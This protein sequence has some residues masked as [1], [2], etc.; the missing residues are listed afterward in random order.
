VDEILVDDLD[1]GNGKTTIYHIVD[2][3]N[4]PDKE[5]VPNSND[6]VFNSGDCYLIVYTY[7]SK[8]AGGRREKTIIY[9]WLV[10]HYWAQEMNT[11]VSRYF[12]TAVQFSPL[13]KDA[14]VQ[15][16]Y[17]SSLKYPQIQILA[18]KYAIVWQRKHIQM[19][20]ESRLSL[21]KCVFCQIVQQCWSN[22]KQEHYS[23]S[24]PYSTNLK[25]RK[26]PD[27]FEEG[28]KPNHYWKRGTSP[29]YRGISYREVLEKTRTFLPLFKFHY[30]FKAFVIFNTIN[31]P[32]KWFWPKW[33]RQSSTYGR[34]C[35]WYRIP[36]WSSS[37][38]DALMYS[39]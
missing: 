31:L 22:A 19:H 34:S 21:Y 27:I 15:A 6:F 17:Q 30:F 25:H 10:S 4:G 36:W 14:F 16:L 20:S 32:G 5:E 37:G 33:T 11:P 2:T 28:T 38:R 3:S 26:D 7:R 35:W 23:C 12:S 9:Y 1:E 13:T 18:R 8:S 39:S 24:N 29:P